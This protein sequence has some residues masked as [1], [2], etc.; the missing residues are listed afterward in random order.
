[1]SD[2]LEFPFPVSKGRIAPGSIWTMED[3]IRWYREQKGDEAVARQLYAARLERGQC[4]CD[5]PTREVQEVGPG[6]RVLHRE[7]CPKHRTW[8]AEFL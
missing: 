1:M 3:Q 6:K 8:M 4:V 7:H 5:R 2:Q